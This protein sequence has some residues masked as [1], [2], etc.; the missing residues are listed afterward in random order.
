[1]RPLTDDETKVFFEKLNEFIGRGIKS[2]LDRPDE[3]H[4]F[5]L[6]DSRVYYASE[7][8]MRQATSISRDELISMGTCFGKFTKSG[9]F[10][11]K[12]TCLGELSQHAKFKVWLKPSAEMSFLYGNHVSKNGIA[13]MTEGVPQFAGVLVLSMS[14]LAL[15]FGRAAH[16]TERCKDLD[17]TSVAILHQSDV[18]EYLREENEIV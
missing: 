1:M 12:V 6:H 15:G 8:V 4:C 13:R 3:P 18:G 7:R 2:L 9:K 11:L 5:R 16:A 10:R 14:N 17:P